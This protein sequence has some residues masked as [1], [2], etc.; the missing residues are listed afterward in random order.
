MLNRNSVFYPDKLKVPEINLQ[1]DYLDEKYED[2]YGKFYDE[3]KLVHPEQMI[4]IEEQPPLRTEVSTA[5]L[6]M[7]KSAKKSIRIIQPYVQNVEE[8]EDLIVEAMEKRG[9]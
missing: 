2:L 1:F 7:I 9:V 8:L 4:F 6:D 5:I 3:Q